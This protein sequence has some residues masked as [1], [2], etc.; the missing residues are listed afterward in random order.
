MEDMT[1]RGIIA[2]LDMENKCGIIYG[3]GSVEEDGK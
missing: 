1:M 2:D 3:I